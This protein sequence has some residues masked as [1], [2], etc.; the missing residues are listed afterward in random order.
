MGSLKSRSLL[1]V[2]IVLVGCSVLVRVTREEPVETR[3]ALSSGRSEAGVLGRVPPFLARVLFGVREQGPEQAT[4]EQVLAHPSDCL[5]GQYFQRTEDG[6]CY[7][8]SAISAG[9]RDG[10]YVWRI[11]GKDREHP[12][13]KYG[14]KQGDL[15]SHLNETHLPLSSET[16]FAHSY[17]DAP[18]LLFEIE[19]DG[20]FRSLRAKELET[21]EIQVDVDD[22]FLREIQI[23]DLPPDGHRY[24]GF[25]TKPIVS[26]K[27]VVGMLVSCRET[28]H[29]LYRLGL[30]DQDR[31]VSLNGIKLDGPES[32]S[33]VYRTLRTSSTLEFGVIRDGRP[34]TITRTL[35]DGAIR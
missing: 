29:P 2:V 20:A 14:L 8:R 3:D 6:A 30:R 23:L 28:R 12:I 33:H 27:E 18:Y 32:L 4:E 21:G 25:M 13:Y 11:T 9:L 19:R 10:E 34:Q 26:E 1:W 24:G 7:A 35:V 16:D 31:V 5:C 17:H 22:I 15:V